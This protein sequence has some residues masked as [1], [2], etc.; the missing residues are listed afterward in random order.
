MATKEGRGNQSGVDPK[1][2]AFSGRK[3]SGNP[4]KAGKMKGKKG[5]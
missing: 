5:Y 4:C 2:A 1:S 3:G